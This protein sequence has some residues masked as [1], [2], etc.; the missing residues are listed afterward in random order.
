[1]D[2]FPDNTLANFTTRLHTP[3][4]LGE[5]SSWEVGMTEIHYPYRWNNVGMDKVKPPEPYTPN[6]IGGDT[7]PDQDSYCITVY[8]HNEYFDHADFWLMPGHYTKASDVAKIY[9]E[10]LKRFGTIS[11]IKNESQVKIKVNANHKFLLTEALARLWG[12]PGTDLRST[13]K[14]GR[15]YRGRRIVDVF[16][17]ITSLYVYCDLATHQI[18][19]DTRVPLTRIVPV[20]G[21]PGANVTKLY[22]NVQYVPCRGG[23]IQNIEVDIRDDTGQPIPFTTGR[24]VVTLH[25]R[26]ARSHYFQP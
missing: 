16:P 23:R 9:G 10:T 13:E 7:R 8:F 26:R 4:D 12:L 15:T 25:L 5:A 20:T 14:A 17:D 11:F 24:V 2:Y 3:L 22:Q 21:K 19:G 18:V 1:M 6:I